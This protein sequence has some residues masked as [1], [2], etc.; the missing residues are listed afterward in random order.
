[1]AG[2]NSGAKGPPVADGVLSITPDTPEI[3]ERRKRSVGLDCAE[4]SSKYLDDGDTG[5]MPPELYGKFTWRIDNFSKISKRE[6]RSNVFEVGSYKWYIL[7][8]PQGCDVCNHLSL[9][10]CVADYEK[11]LPGWNHFAQFT[12]AV[13]NS[14]PKKSKYSDTLHRFCKKEHDWGWKKFMELNKVLEGFIVD[15]QLVIKAQVQVIRDSPQRPFRCLDAHYRREL[16]RVYISNVETLCQQFIEERRKHLSVTIG[17]EAPQETQEAF[18]A[19]WKRLSTNRRSELLQEKG[20]AFL[21]KLVKR[22]FN[23]KEVTSSLVM[24]ALFVG[25]KLLEAATAAKKPAPSQVVFLDMK[26]GLFYLEGDSLQLWSCASFDG[27]LSSNKMHA[28]LGL[29]AEGEL[30]VA[31]DN[32]DSDERKLAELGRRTVEMFT[33]AHIFGTKLQAAFQEEQSLRRQEE[34]IREEEE[35]RLAADERLQRKAEADKERRAKKK[36]KKKEK[37][38][39]ED[40]KRAEEERDAKA[41]AEQLS[42]A[43]QAAMAQAQQARDMQQLQQEKERKAAIEA[44]TKARA[45]QMKVDAAFARTDAE[46]SGARKVGNEDDEERWSAE[47]MYSEEPVCTSGQRSREG[48][49]LNGA[50]GEA[51]PHSASGPSSSKSLGGEAHRNGEQASVHSAA[52]SSTPAAAGAGDSSA[53]ASAN[54]S[55]DSATGSHDSVT[56]A[57]AEAVE[58]VVAVRIQALQTEHSQR[59]SEMQKR[60]EVAERTIA[61]RD[62]EIA[63]LKQQLVAAHAE[64]MTQWQP[65]Q[66]MEVASAASDGAAWHTVG[67]A[68]STVASFTAAPSGNHSDN[69]SGSA[70]PS[71]LA[72]NDMR[73]MRPN[74]ATVV[75]RGGHT[76]ATEAASTG[77]HTPVKQGRANGRAPRGAITS[78]TL[79]TSHGLVTASLVARQVGPKHQQHNGPVNPILQRSSAWAGGAPSTAAPGASQVPPQQPQQAGLPPSPTVAPQRVRPAFVPGGTTAASQLDRGS[80]MDAG[81][82]QVDHGSGAL[83]CDAPAVRGGNPSDGTGFI[84]PGMHDF[85]HIDL[86]EDL[87]S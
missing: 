9:F 23:E 76:P 55:T 66:L 53:C 18:Q 22:F 13:V 83:S 63:R 6:L 47:S 58:A 28:D 21:P 57:D 8:Y 64:A 10:L 27:S 5:P 40:A 72:K 52:L 14:D 68:S 79:H 82:L 36:Q 70:T 3:A 59:L 44:T 43:K 54:G 62:A 1:M 2:T 78:A 71:H 85:Q 86:I 7:V 41:R 77:Q 69:S 30:A 4:T 35:A 61:A 51:A 19:F 74:S 38:D 81:V 25:C 24:D 34:L 49:W 12:I 42:A 26:R 50:E 45:V 87:F 32:V 17:G 75:G 33:I 31:V 29:R 48:R 37:K 80:S 20:S 60:L 84:S 39:A 46:G 56:T 15:N 16:V 73:S 67:K 65:A 11:L